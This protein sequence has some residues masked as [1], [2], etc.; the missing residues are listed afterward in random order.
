[1]WTYVDHGE[2]VDNTRIS[3]A[4][5]VGHHL[6]FLS[7]GQKMQSLAILWL[8]AGTFSAHA[9]PVENGNDRDPMQVRLAYAGATGMHVSWN[10]YA[11]VHKPSVRWGT[12]P[13][14]LN[15]VASSGVSVTYETSST[16]SNH[17][18]IG[19]LKPDT[20]YYYLPQHSGK[21]AE[22]FSFRT[23]RI[24]GDHT[25]FTAAVVVDL[26][27]VSKFLGSIP[28]EI[29]ADHTQRC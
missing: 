19:G 3:G 20:L 26:G 18:K 13:G 12:S 23:S 1:M 5:D 11:Q 9:T 2:K 7:N 10:T 27:T 4:I 16:Y 14:K 6:S 28:T 29:C 15:N 17:V 25:P 8:L 24:T 22:P 21:K